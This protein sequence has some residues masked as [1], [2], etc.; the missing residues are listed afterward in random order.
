MI[1]YFI[2]IVAIFIATIGDIFMK[3]SEGFRIKRYTAFTLTMYI[4]TFYLLSIVM[5]KLPVGI[6]YATWSGIGMILTAIVGVV[7]FKES[8]NGKIIF[9]LGVILAGVI[10][11]NLN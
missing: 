8:M 3:K 10:I 7:L 1:T 4:L 5:L 2:L 9:A 6:A 11:I